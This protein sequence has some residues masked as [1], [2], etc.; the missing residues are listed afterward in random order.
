MKSPMI[1]FGYAAFLFACGLT[2]FAMAG[3]ESRAKTALIVGASTAAIM[4]ICG[5]LARMIH[6]RRGLGM[7]GI[8]AGLVLPLLFAALLGWRA[9]KTF[10]HGGDEKRYLAVILTIMVAAS[11]AAFVAILLTRPPKAQRVK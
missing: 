3:F 1:M 8:H 10:A 5:L 6:A 9:Y 7:I 4:V 11:V 2:A